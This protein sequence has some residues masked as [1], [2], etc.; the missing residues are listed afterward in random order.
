MDSQQG[1]SY[2]EFTYQLLQAYDF[3]TLHKRHNCS[4]QIGGSDQWGNILA[5]LEMI[6]RLDRPAE[7]ADDQ[8]EKG[9][10][11]TTPLLTTAS[12]EKF[13]KSAGN[14]VWLDDK[15][16]SVFDFYQVRPMPN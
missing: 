10:G 1:I 14:A 8:R 15:L 9:F 12:G 4:I 11:I 16:T 7:E 13:G 5:G 2:T 3:Y 6:D